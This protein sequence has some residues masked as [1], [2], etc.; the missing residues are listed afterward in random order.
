MSSPNERFQRLENEIVQLRDAV[1]E[2]SGRLRVTED[3]VRNLPRAPRESGRRWPEWINALIACAALIVSIWALRSS[4]RSASEALHTSERAYLGFGNVSIYCQA[5]EHPDQIKAPETFPAE[6]TAIFLVN[7]LN[8]GKTPASIVDMN[9]SRTVTTG[10]RMQRDFDFAEDPQADS[11]PEYLAPDPNYPLPVHVPARA[12]E[13]LIARGQVPMQRPKGQS[14]AEYVYIYGH[15]TYRDVFNNRHVLLFCREFTGPT[16]SIPEH[17]SRCPLH[18]GEDDAYI[19]KKG[20]NI[21]G[22]ALPEN[23]APEPP[24]TFPPAPR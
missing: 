23:R 13:V 5:C 15:V 21:P 20:P 6:A 10:Q 12:E 7:V 4:D 3:G 9:F 18:E 24:N 16:N 19:P 17:W 1:S 2:L 14:G 22:M 8:Y 11:G